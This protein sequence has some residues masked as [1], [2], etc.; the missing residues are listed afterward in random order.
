MKRILK[1]DYKTCYKNTQ[2]FKGELFIET[3]MYELTVT[4]PESPNVCNETIEQKNRQNLTL[5][6]CQRSARNIYCSYLMVV[7]L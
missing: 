6:V 2:P 7:I 1:A 5:L 3:K 4:P